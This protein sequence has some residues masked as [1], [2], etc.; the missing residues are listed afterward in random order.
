M[1]EIVNRNVKRVNTWN[2]K[3]LKVSVAV[4]VCSFMLGITCLCP[5]VQAAGT[6]TVYNVSSPS[7]VVAGSEAPIPVT[8]TIY[9][10]NT[11]Q[12]YELV[13]GIL[14]ADLTPETIVPGIVASSTDPCINQPEPAALCAIM[15]PKSSGVERIG[16]QIGGI[17]GGR[18]QVGRWDLNITSALIGP[19]NTIIPGSVSNKLFEVNLTSVALNVIV[20]AQVIVSIDGVK[21]PPGPASVGVALGQHNIT[22]PE[23]VNV[24]K[25]TRLR[26]DGWSDGYPALV[27][28]II[29]INDTTLKVVYVT[30]NLLTLVGVGGNSSIAW[31]DADANATLFV[32]PNETLG[33]VV[34]AIGGRLTFGGW[35]ENGTL[36][37]GSPTTIIAMSKPHTVTAVWQ[38]D[39]TIPTAVVL[40]VVAVVV[41][42]FLALRRRTKPGRTRRRARPRRKRT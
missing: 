24:T 17:F 26:F 41:V 13:V 39:Y 20:P 33:G 40:A 18:R 27:R 25:S 42:I 8:A 12:G 22:V 34:G 5:A 30:Q 32:N 2:A 4:I 16:F 38:V 35:Y 6:T 37:S 36:V 21:E 15:V 29:M 3:K 10:N 1:G 28:D 23:L 7:S 19:Q 11:I 9:Y 31:Y 14:D